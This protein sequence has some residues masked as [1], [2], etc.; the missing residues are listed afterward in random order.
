MYRPPGARRPHICRR[1]DVVPADI[2]GLVLPQGLRRTGYDGTCAAAGKGEGDV[3]R[4]SSWKTVL[5]RQASHR[6]E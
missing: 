2:N 6:D 3:T 4:H 5:R 1:P